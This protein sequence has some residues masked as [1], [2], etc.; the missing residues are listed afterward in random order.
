MRGVNRE[1]RLPHLMAVPSLEALSV[2]TPASSSST[3]PTPCRGGG[4]VRVCGL[5]G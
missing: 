2:S 4:V 3:S 5:H 1:V